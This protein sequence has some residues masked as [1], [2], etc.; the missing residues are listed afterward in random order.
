[1]VVKSSNDNT[2]YWLNP[3]EPFLHKSTG[4]WNLKIQ[5]EN[6]IPDHTKRR[7]CSISSS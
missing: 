6:L 1:M 7:Q 4:D 3:D 5:I 2:Y